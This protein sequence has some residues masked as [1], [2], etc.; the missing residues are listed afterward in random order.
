MRAN[1]QALRVG[2]GGPV[3]SGKTAL[4]E[5]TAARLAGRLRFGVLAGDGGDELFGGYETYVAQQ[6]GQRYDAMPSTYQCSLSSTFHAISAPQISASTFANSRAGT[7]DIICE[8][9]FA[10]MLVDGTP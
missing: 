8:T 10:T 1:R 5:A 2:V 7:P 4:L 9:M 3:G 6:F